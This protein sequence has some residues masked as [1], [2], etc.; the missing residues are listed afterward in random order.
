MKAIEKI[1]EIIE[2]LKDNKTDEI[3]A[4]EKDI[5]SKIA[6]IDE[7]FITID[8]NDDKNFFEYNFDGV[9]KLLNES[10]YKV[11]QA[12]KIIKDIKDVILVKMNLGDGFDISLEDSQV[13]DLKRIVENLQ[14]IKE[15]LQ[16]RLEEIGTIKINQNETRISELSALK[17]ILEGKGRRR[18]YTRNMFNVFMA[19]ADIA[20]MDPEEALEILGDFFDT[21]NMSTDVSYNQKQVE[22]EDFDAIIDLYKEY[23]PEYFK[24]SKA[25][26]GEDIKDEFELNLLKRKKHIIYEID[27]DNTREILNWLRERGLLRKFDRKALI[28]ISIYGDINMIEKAY[29][30]LKLNNSYLGDKVYTGKY[31]VY[32][33]NYSEETKKYQKIR[34]GYT[35]H[36][37]SDGTSETKYIPNVYGQEIVKNIKLLEQLLDEEIID[38]KIKKDDEVI[39]FKPSWR[40]EKNVKLAKAF[41]LGTKGEVFLPPTYLYA[42]DTE[43]AANAAIE[44]GLLHSPMDEE[45]K[46]MDSRLPRN[47][48][49]QR[50]SYRKGK[51]NQTVRD[52]YS[53]YISSLVLLSDDMIRYLSYIVA[54]EGYEALYKYLLSDKNAGVGD[55]DTIRSMREQTKESQ[56]LDKLYNMDD[57]PEYIEDYYEIDESVAEYE[58]EL[59]NNSED[60]INPEILNNELI[61]DLEENYRVDDELILGSDNI[62]KPNNYVYKIGDRLISR[63]KVLHIAS[64]LKGLN[65][66]LNKDMLLYAITKDSYF[67]EKDFFTIVETI[68]GKENSL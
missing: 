46:S 59:K 29:N 20:N 67:N 2:N 40:L 36:R 13:E 49:F 34:K 54:T 47:E 7:C 24:S 35:T 25:D 51:S 66:Y 50:N 52:Y 26:D 48:E 9:I 17:D 33:I 4:E 65:G 8:S 53:R 1:N 42:K 14:K 15:N 64:I 32:W 39:T 19:E 61:M 55:W 41:G 58:L 12:D 6:L 44:L 62:V 10:E 30:S 18:Y 23:V 5:L 27:I 63:K 45:F 37:K 22:P 11:D 56:M 31:S 38:S 57:Y 3:I 21:R 60:Y 68:K 16:K 28:D 43:R